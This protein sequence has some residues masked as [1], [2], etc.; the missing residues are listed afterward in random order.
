MDNRAIG[1]FDSGIGGLTVVREVKK[2]LGAED[3]CYFGDTARV[4][5][6]SKSQDIV[7]KFSR[8][9]VNFLI[10]RDVKAIIIACNTV[11]SNCYEALSKEYDIPFLEVVSPGVEACLA[12]TKNNRVGLIGTE[13][14]V[15]S[16]AYEKLLKSTRPEIQVY[17]QACPL[18]VP[19]VEEGWTD[20]QVTALTIQSYISGLLDHGIDSLLLG[21]THYPWLTDALQKVAGSVHIVNPAITCAVKMKTLLEEKS[22]HN[23]INLLKNQKPQHTYYVSDSPEKF[24]QIAKLLLNEDLTAEKIDIEGY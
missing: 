24:N 15:K 20:N 5:Y 13:R 11:S 8:Q 21:C 22:L 4:P 10:S 2:L 18:F 14:T 23:E 19:L 12:A 9:I 17:S 16:Q 3:I 1:I 7:L 6:G